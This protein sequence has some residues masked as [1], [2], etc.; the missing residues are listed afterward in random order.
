M[1]VADA[2]LA[3]IEA[4]DV[5]DDVRIMDFEAGLS[6]GKIKYIEDDVITGFIDAVSERALNPKEIDKN[7]SIVYTPL[8][9]TGRYCVTRCLKENG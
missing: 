7:V 5:F 6:E 3:E 4:V 2:I 9:G 8:N 1:E